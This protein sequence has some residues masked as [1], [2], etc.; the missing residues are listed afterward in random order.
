MCSA[1]KYVSTTTIQEIRCF[2]FRRE[3]GNS[4]KLDPWFSNYPHALVQHM[5]VHPSLSAHHDPNESLPRTDQT[6]PSITTHHPTHDHYPYGCWILTI[7]VGY[8]YYGWSVML[9][10]SQPTKPT[11]THQLAIPS[12]DSGSWPSRKGAK[13][14]ALP[15]LRAWFANGKSTASC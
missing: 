2:Y 7:V 11:Q 15:R 4:C 6:V 8:Y 14:V 9:T 5:L 10:N 12:V 3:S 1:S 13:S